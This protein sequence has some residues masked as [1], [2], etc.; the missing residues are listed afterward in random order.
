M[1]VGFDSQNTSHSFLHYPNWDLWAPGI[2]RGAYS[3][4]RVCINVATSLSSQSMGNKDKKNKEKKK[5]KK[6][7]KKVNPNTPV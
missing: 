4:V 1:F 5:P 6:D 2:P 7:K 3:W